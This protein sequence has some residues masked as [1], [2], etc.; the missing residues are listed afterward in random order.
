MISRRFVLP[1]VVLSCLLIGPTVASAQFQDLIK[2]I[3]T[4]PNSLILLNVDGIVRSPLG[5]R[6]GWRGDQEK[7]YSAGMTILP[8]DTTKVV[9]AAKLDLEF[10]KTTWESAILEVSYDHSMP[11]IAMRSGGT[12]DEIAGREAALLPSDTYVVKFGPTKIGAMSPANR[13]NVSYWVNSV[14]NDAKRKPLTEYLTEAV[15]FAE[16]VGTPII[17]AL[18]LENSVS[19]DRIRSRLHRFQS[20]KGKEEHFDELAELLSQIR[21]V[22]LGVTITDTM[23]GKL[24]VDFNADATPLASIAQPLLLDVL[25]HNGAMINEFHDWKAVISGNQ[26]SIGG[27]LYE[28]GLRRLLSVLDPP[29]SIQRKVEQ[30]SDPSSAENKEELQKLATQQYWNSLNSMVKDLQTQRKSDKV[31]TWGQVGLWFEKY[32][33]KIDQLPILN[34]DEDLVDFG[35]YVATQLRDAERSMKGIGVN[36]RMRETTLPNYTKSYAWGNTIG[37][38]RWGRHGSYNVVATEDLSRRG[39]ERSRIRTQESIRGNTAAN[40]T[41][42]GVQQAFADMRRH[43][44]QK[45]QVEFKG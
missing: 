4:R 41:M 34:V 6:E 40:L 12:V 7:A 35:A 8:P 28:S 27:P 37:V 23:Y 2:R 32:A 15:S 13:Q 14:Y 39:Q 9:M 3:P 10:M 24:K 42:Q 44:T 25:A 18:D 33:A 16:D 20:L 1:L 31:V 21:G 38:T 17:M 5:S 11:K 19:A 22:T 26:V 36:K 29:P 30:T 45:Y 43:L